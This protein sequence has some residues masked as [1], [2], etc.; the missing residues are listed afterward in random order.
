MKKFKK[1]PLSI[2]YILSIGFIT[3]I[4]LPGIL[5]NYGV[6]SIEVNVLPL[7]LLGSWTPNIAAFLVIAFVLKEK[8]GVKSL[9]ARWTHFK[10]G[11]R[12]Y[13]VA[14]SPILVALA[15][16]MTVNLF[17]TIPAAEGLPSPDMVAGLLLMSLITGA[18]GEEL[19]WRGFALPRLLKRYNAINA[20]LILGF[21]WGIWHLPLWFT[22]MGWEEIPFLLFMYLGICMTLVIT[23][24]FIHTNG[25]MVLVTLFHMSFNISLGLVTQFWQITMYDTVM[26]ISGG[27][28]IYMLVVA[29]LLVKRKPAT[30]FIYEL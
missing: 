1:N 26:Y 29:T 16:V 12:W 13:L 7:M 6:I 22:G 2:F 19:G 18:T 25:N 20:S 24:M 27:F 28:T 11:T 3:L 21:I 14:L 23:W 10:V 15:A 9:F 4:A 17:T 5:I 30:A 8:G